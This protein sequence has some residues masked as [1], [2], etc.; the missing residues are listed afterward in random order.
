MRE[1]AIREFFARRS[2]S[3]SDDYLA[4]NGGVPEAA[5]ILSFPMPRD[6]ALVAQ[7]AA[8]LLREIY[9]LRDSTALDIRYTENE[10]S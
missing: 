7:I 10:A 3:P 9:R 1:A 4:A 6:A 5:R 2:I 8:D